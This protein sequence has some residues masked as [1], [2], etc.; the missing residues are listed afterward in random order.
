MDRL[1]WKSEA[2]TALASYAAAMLMLLSL[3]A[4]G[5]GAPS[6]DGDDATNLEVVRGM[7][8]DVEAESLIS[9]AALEVQDDGGKVWRFEGRGEGRAGLYAIASERT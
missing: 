4:C 7:V 6:M 2:L 8:V 1:I 9:L 3:A 5:D